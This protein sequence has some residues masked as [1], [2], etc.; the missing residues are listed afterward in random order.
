LGRL[1]RQDVDLTKPVSRD[2]QLWGELAMRPV[3]S[4][5]IVRLG[6][7]E[8]NPRIW[9]SLP[10]LQGANRFAGVKP[11]AQILA[12]TSTGEPLLVAGE[13]GR[14]RVLAF[15]G[16]STYRWWQ[17]GKPAEHRRFWRQI[18]L[19]L[20][21][22]DETAQNDVWIKLPQRR[23]DP[24]APISF[25]SGARS[26][27]GDVIRD[28]SFT[29]RLL[30]PDGKSK[31]IRLVT[32][33]EQVSGALEPIEQ[34]GDYLIEAEAVQS[35]R[36][37]GKARAH[38]QVLDRDV[39]LGNPAANYDLLARLANLTKDAGGRPVAPEQLP[40]LL[41][42]LT[43]RRPEM[44]IEIESRWQLGD[45]A[46]DAWLFLLGLVGL[47]TAEWIVRKRWGLV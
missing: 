25:T 36:T 46:A 38:F 32:D 29:A 47:L 24:G 23:F 13:Y 5:P 26:A 22:R 10:A 41:R 9:S 11:R 3:R 43:E 21:Q 33:Q 27:A 4:H 39:E 2:L 8:E 18:I 45:T 12:E 40:D 34:P 19:W 15:A 28:A 35:G 44:Q 7:E 42:E 14:G 20:A 17:Y 37:L 16:N 31:T 6:T 1:E 30:L